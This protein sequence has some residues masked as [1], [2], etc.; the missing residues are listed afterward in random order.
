MDLRTALAAVL[1]VGLGALLL[2]YPDAVVR[3]H[4]A[5]RLPHDRRGEFGADAP[6]PDRWR[7]LVRGLGAVSVIAGLYFATT[8][9]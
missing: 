1:G 3:A 2:A 8:L 5:G 7:L 9:L 6:A 4:T